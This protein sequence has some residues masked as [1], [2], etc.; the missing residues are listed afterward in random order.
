MDRPHIICHMMTALD[1]K[2][3]GDYMETQTA[4]NSSGGTNQ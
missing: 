1:G 4:K 3:I 2:I